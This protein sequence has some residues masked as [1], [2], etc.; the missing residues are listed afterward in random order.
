MREASPHLPP[1]PII[2]DMRDETALCKL[3]VGLSTDSAPLLECAKRVGDSALHGQVAFL[4]DVHMLLQEA[5]GLR[6][7]YSAHETE[8]DRKITEDYVQKVQCMKRYGN[9]MLKN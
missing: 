2:L 7:T 6:V 1:F 3:H 4:R 8:E 9:L 5:A